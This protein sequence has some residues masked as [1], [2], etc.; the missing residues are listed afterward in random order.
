MGERVRI[1]LM[2]P[3]ELIGRS[4][5]LN[6]PT[7]GNLLLNASPVRLRRFKGLILKR[8]ISESAAV[9]KPTL[10]SKSDSLVT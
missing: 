5:L 4:P 1:V 6:E 8:N 2:C 3:K 7:P 9:L 10:R